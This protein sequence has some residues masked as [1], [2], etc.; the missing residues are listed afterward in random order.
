MR[1]AE[2]STEY[3]REEG[4]T[5]EGAKG[6]RRNKGEEEEESTTAGYVINHGR[7]ED[8]APNQF[9]QK[10]FPPTNNQSW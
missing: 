3:L 5:E 1:P 8:G 10:Y 6:R 2:S 4:I 7:K 9:N